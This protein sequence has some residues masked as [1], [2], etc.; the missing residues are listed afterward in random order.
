MV[1]AAGSQPSAESLMP[2]FDHGR[3]HDL[4]TACRMSDMALSEEATNADCL[5]GGGQALAA[6]PWGPLA[7]RAAGAADLHFARFILP[8]S[9]VLPLPPCSTG[10]AL[11]VF[12][13]LGLV[14]HSGNG[15]ELPI[16]A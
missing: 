16:F 9:L 3:C 12:D 1:E 10:G 15:R 8:S 2:S 7:W 14:P 6:G 5:R 11:Q 13:R 4:L